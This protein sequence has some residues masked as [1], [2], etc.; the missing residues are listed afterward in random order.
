MIITFRTLNYLL[1]IRPILGGNN[2]SGTS[3]F[4]CGILS[5]C[6][7]FAC[8]LALRCADI[9]QLPPMHVGTPSHG[10]TQRIN[11]NQTANTK[12]KVVNVEKFIDFLSLF[13]GIAFFIFVICYDY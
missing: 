8:G 5:P 4:V 13:S 3:L 1:F 12:M 2:Y 7:G 10:K 9:E 11:M 6:T